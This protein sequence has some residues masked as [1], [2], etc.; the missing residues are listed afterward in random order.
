MNWLQRLMVV[1]AS[2][3]FGAA[4]L[5]MA[6]GRESAEQTKMP[7]PKH[8]AAVVYP[9]SALEKGIEGIV[10]VKI[11]VDETGVVKKAEVEKSDNAELNSAAV[12]AAKEW[13]FSPAVSKEGKP[14]G[15]WVTVP[16]KFKLEPKE[17]SKTK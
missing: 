10:Y 7:E 16:F 2:L 17:K 1:V 14:V 3:T 9:K 4:V 12:D 5:G 11:Y 8:R 15:V 6:W 13:T